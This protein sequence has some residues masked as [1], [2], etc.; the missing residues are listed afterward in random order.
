MLAWCDLHLKGVEEARKQLTEKHV[1]TLC[2]RIVTKV[3][4]YEK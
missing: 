3:T 4:W 1:N 2:G